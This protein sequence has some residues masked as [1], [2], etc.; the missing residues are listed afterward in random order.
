M[1]GFYSTLKESEAFLHCTFLTGV[2]KF[3]RMGVFSSL[4]NINDISLDPEYA[5]LMG[6]THDEPVKNFG[7]FSA[8]NTAKTSLR[9]MAIPSL[10]FAP[11][12]G[13]WVEG[14]PW[15]FNMLLVVLLQGHLWGQKLFLLFFLL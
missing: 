14:Q 2:S 8:I 12:P 13:A 9:S 1:R 10:P 5:D 3:S 7:P 15:K 6:Y 4:N 11:C